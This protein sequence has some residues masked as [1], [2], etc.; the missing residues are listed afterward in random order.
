MRKIA[1]FAVIVLAMLAC[2]L[3]P[4]S[5]TRPT[6]VAQVTQTSPPAGEVS[7]QAKAS[8]TPRPAVTA[9]PVTARV[10]AS[11]P[12]DEY[13][14]S[15]PFVVTFDQPMDTAS[16]Q[17]ALYTYPWVDGELTW[18]ADKTRLSLSPRH[19]FTPNRAYQIMLNNDL[20][21]ATGGSL[22]EKSQWELRALAGPRVVEHSPSASRLLDRSPE[23][24]V[25]FDREMSP[26]SLEQAFTV[27][28]ALSYHLIVDNSTLTVK[29]E[30]PLTP[31]I[32]YYFNLDTNAQDT[33]GVPL[34][35]EY[36]WDY[37]LPNLVESVSTD[38]YYRAQDRF[39]LNLNYRLRQV[40]T[41]LPTITPS[42]DGNWAWLN[43]NRLVFRSEQAPS[44]LRS[45]T[46]TFPDELVD[47]DGEILVVN[48]DFIITPPPPI[49]EHFPEADSYTELP[50]NISILFGIPMDRA[51]TQAAFQIDPKIS[52]SFTWEG[53]LLTFVPATG[54][55]VNTMYTVTLETS[56]LDAAGEPVLLA[57]YRWNFYGGYYYDY[58]GVSFGE[59]GPNIQVVDFDGRRAVQFVNW[60]DNTTVRFELYRLTLEQFLQ[61]YSSG[62]RGAAGFQRSPV[63]LEGA[64]FIRNWDQNVSRRGAGWD[65]NIYETVIPQE[66]EAGL[67]V[68]NLQGLNNND[69]L[70]LVLTR[71]TLMVKQAEGQITTWV[72]D[73]DGG[74]RPGAS[75]GIYARDGQ[76]LAQ[77]RA[78]QN[79]VF[80]T[81]VD[82]DPQP[83]IIVAM[84]NER[85]TGR[86]I[87][88]TDVTISGLGNE[89]RS[90]SANQWWGWWQ[91]TP[92]ATDFAA[93][94]YTDRPIYKPGQTVFFK[95]ILRQD[96]DAELSTM[97][98]GT[99]VTVRVR[100]A[101][102]NIVQTYEL[103]T[104]AYGTVNAE[105]QIAQGA[106]LGKY[107]LEVIYDGES[108]RQLFKVQ[109]YRKPDFQITI[110]TDSPSYVDGE[111]AQAT[112]DTRYFFGEP[113]AGAKLSLRNYYL[114]SGYFWWGDEVAT[115]P[116]YTW[117]PQGE[118]TRA[119]TDEN[120]RYVYD[121][122]PPAGYAYTDRYSSNS[123]IK[124]TIGLEVTV[125]DGSH[126]TVSAFT[127]FNVYN[128]AEQVSLD[129]GGFLKEPN[130]A[131]MVRGAVNTIFEDP[132][133][134]R[135]LTLEVRQYNR[136]SYDFDTV[137]QMANFSTNDQGAF[138]SLVTIAQSGYYQL[139]VS[140]SDSRGRPMFAKAWV[141][142]IRTG[143]SWASDYVE[144]LRITA[145]EAQYAPG[146]TA[147]L[148]IESSFSGPALL[149]IERGSTRRAQ[150]VSLTSPL[151]TVEVPIEAGDA[152]NVFVIVN[153][154]RTQQ[155]VLNQETYNNMPDS[156]LR[157]ALVE[158]I[159]PV[160]DKKLEVDLLP[161][162]DAYAPRQQASFTV[163]VKDERGNPVVAE[164]SL[165]LVDEAIF[166]LS[167]EL[168]GPIF[169]AF[170]SPRPH[171]VRTYD[172]M[173]PTR[174]LVALGRG[175]GGG[176]GETSG[177][178][179]DFPD[180]AAWFPAIQTDANGEAVINIDLPDSL[181][182]WRLTAKAISAEHQVGEAHVNIVTRQEIVVRP[183]LPRT[184]TE[185][186]QVDIS[187]AVHNYTS[188]P[189]SLDVWLA[190]TGVETQIQQPLTQTLD[191][192]PGEVRILG[193]PVTVD[194]PG[195]AQVTVHARSP[196]D[197]K[198]SDAVLLALPVKPLAV[199]DITSQVGEVEGSLSTAL[200]VPEGV[201]EQSTFKIDVSRSI[202]GSLLN[203][204]EYLTGYPYGCV[205]QTMSRAL[206]NAVVG[207]ALN[208]LGV[209]NP[210][211][212]AELPA[213]IN[214]GL[215]RLYG[216]QH[217]DGGWG[218]WFDDQTHD[219]QTAWVVF[220]L[221]VTAQ[222]GYEVDPQV[223]QRGA[224]WLRANLEQ[225]DLRT[226][227]YALYSLAIAGYG[228]LPDTL[229]L[230]EQ[231][232]EL[233][234]FSQAGLALALQT[235]GAQEDALKILDLL[236]E[237]ATQREGLIYWVNPNEDGH[238]YEKTMSSSLRSTAL[239]LEAFVQ[240]APG[241][242]LE[243]GIVRW[244]MSQR[245]PEGW[246]STNETS[247][248]ILALTD[249]LKTLEAATVQT[250]YEILLNGQSIAS[251][252][253]GPGEPAVSLEF[254]VTQMH[255][256]A[257]ALEVRQE[258]STRLFYTI[259]SRMLFPQADIQPAG[260]VIIGRVYL[261]PETGE[262]IDTVTA[263][264][265]VKVVL[266]VQLPD[267]GFFI[268]VEDKLP[269]GLE[270]LNESLNITS[271]E[272][273][274]YNEEPHYYWQEYGYNNKEVRA[275][276][277]SFFITEMDA[278]ERT[279]TYLARATRSGAFVAMP[280]EVSAMYDATLW[281]R[282]ASNRL[283]VVP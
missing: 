22:K 116:E 106:M 48:N 69:Q 113:V 30:Q 164:V 146:D 47:S 86:D 218:W 149:T 44:P 145:D 158:L 43:P 229:K 213:L 81:I 157:S 243:G 9:T 282:S 110:S 36:R 76:R 234:T 94:T 50:T 276:R 196:V 20:K 231:V 104:N 278:R 123:L 108:R 125:D 235:L 204:L 271:H 227:A 107:T 181:T 66:V 214:A 180:T 31:G 85:M 254:P 101:R 124:S 11:Q 102:D 58:T 262:P 233:D 88:G 161:G 103:A 70:L 25:S 192:Q 246:G 226:R 139:R 155:N 211:L 143:S 92:K 126:Q 169:D 225:M 87:E 209:S 248:T 150:P 162:Q 80:T 230:A 251:G 133:P 130:Q 274:L 193:W 61:R 39:V 200:V 45:Y 187:A 270:A 71:N 205:E 12:L 228:D 33:R 120:G 23:I 245:R 268:I 241:H 267:N 219:Y 242:A 160:S 49:I 29:L 83:L 280:A 199:P 215:Q 166:S 78:D 62:F 144:D 247:F 217:N 38:S 40:T 91:P 16:A 232:V 96:D 13:Q 74:S 244:L 188:A 168:S 119:V 27:Q 136:N 239:A 57:P 174:E 212:Q 53:N 59:F 147:T 202:A 21:S 42:I 5:G 65:G 255:V 35:T 18:S 208:Q 201:L 220:G 105:F 156:N 222:A 257:N 138:E 203:G 279:F 54:L 206:P 7:N 128:S 153:A 93:Y 175:G 260:A 41:N 98:E 32:R 24:R 170:Y 115:Q 237:S 178:R 109:D 73:I 63:S 114:E 263:G 269:G 281:G 19:G 272:Q 134:D 163:Q 165:A 141:Y 189:V 172:S 26:E 224:D 64:A 68:L 283:E 97:P 265:L 250:P 154:W 129:V 140:G 277:V 179:S 210:S 2:T 131:F 253:F 258:G 132:V 223:I 99:P 171:I 256:G 8:P 236:A 37:S 4:Q 79:G 137:V 15:A 17:P 173:A 135:A 151:T 194:S 184:L 197:D 183:F 275:D 198:A 3:F 266:R 182:S 46:V 221:S 142:A 148:I 159:V 259:N 1:F 72:T 55:A 90:S 28:P 100:D 14:P 195:E 51:S 252:E 191:L 84:E 240:I 118:E 177:P 176:D 190:I 60:G 122:F 238:Y 216:Y 89:F 56:A 6:E 127:I 121:F 152:P 185:G 273:N 167:E 111:S 261:E 52:G 249:H 34:T 112:I 10:D 207:R 82:R 117:Y 186:D 95:T 264:E 75:V 67:Y 77:G